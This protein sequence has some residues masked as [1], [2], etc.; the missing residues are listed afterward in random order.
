RQQI[1]HEVCAVDVAILVVGDFFHHGGGKAHRQ[2]AVDLTF[3]D[4]RVDTPAAIIYRNEAADFHFSSAAV[5]I[6]NT[7][8]GPER[9]GQ[10]WRVV[11]ADRFQAAFHA[12]WV[13]R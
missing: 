11:I 1:I 6:H 2:A 8:I 12:L 9:I 10:V 4:H 3:D 13:I 5:N 7:D